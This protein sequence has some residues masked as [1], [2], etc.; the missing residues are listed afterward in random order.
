MSVRYGSRSRPGTMVSTW[1]NSLVSGTAPPGRAGYFG[2]GNTGSTVDTVESFG[3]PSDTRS[4]L[5]ATLSAARYS[6]VG[7]ANSGT[8]GYFAGGNGSTVVDKLSFADD[9]MSALGTGMSSNWYNAAGFAN[10]GTAGYVAGGIEADAG[11]RTDAVEKFTFSDD[12][13]ST[14]GAVLTNTVDQPAGMANSGTAGYVA[15]GEYW[16]AGSVFVTT[17]DKFAFPADS[18]STLGTGLSAATMKLAGMAN[19]GTAGYFGG[20]TTGST[21]ATVDKFDFSDDSR[22]TL[23]TGLSAATYDLAGMAD[24]GTAGYFGGGY[25]ASR[26]TTVDK[27]DFS[28]DS[29]STLGT[30]LATATWRLAAFANTSGL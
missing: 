7:F 18:K 30:G 19:S 3:F 21:V 22:S 11:G 13:R 14:L 16:S 27:F 20:G 12:S 1:L 24:S 15:G 23:G 4:T 9:T 25:T 29:R 28:D 17:V 10:S 2:G 26:V 5:V 6:L 8:A